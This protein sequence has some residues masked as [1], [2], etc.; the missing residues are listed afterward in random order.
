M[1]CIFCPEK[2]VNDI[3]IINY[4]EPIK[5]AINLTDNSLKAFDASKYLKNHNKKTP[6]T[7]SGMSASETP[8]E[9]SNYQIISKKS[10]ILGQE[11]YVEYCFSPDG[12]NKYYL[13]YHNDNSKEIYTEKD[14]FRLLNNK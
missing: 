1:Y 8:H 9:I 3:V 11:S 5:L 10:A 2:T 14:Y 6:E 4:N 13:L 7:K 12:Q